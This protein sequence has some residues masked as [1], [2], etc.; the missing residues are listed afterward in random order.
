LPL[1]R[2]VLELAEEATLRKLVFDAWG[3]PGIGR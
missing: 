1:G 2:E 3:Y